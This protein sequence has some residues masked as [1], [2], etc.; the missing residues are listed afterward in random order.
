MDGFGYSRMCGLE[1]LSSPAEAAHPI[2]HT[3]FRGLAGGW[4]EAVRGLWGPCVREK[5]RCCMKN[6]SEDCCFHNTREAVA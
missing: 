3:R 6:A 1:G 4:G 5:L 2:F